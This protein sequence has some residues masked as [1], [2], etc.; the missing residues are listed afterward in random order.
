MQPKSLSATALHVSEL[1]LARYKAEHIDRAARV[2]TSAASLGTAV[3]GALEMFVKACYLDKTQQPS[4]QLL[5][6]LYRM[7]YMTTFGTSDCDTEQFWDGA[8]MLDRWAKRTVWDGITVLS[9]EVKENFPVPTSLGDI[10]FNYI[11]DRF[12]RIGEREVKVVDYKTNKWSINPADL[13]KKIQAR[14]YGVA[15]AIK[16]KSLGFEVDKVWVEF[17]LLRHDPVGIVFSREENAATWK[18]IK[19]AAQK[20]IDTPDDET[21]ESLNTECLFCV[22]KQTCKAIAS[23]IAAGGI[24]GLN[25]DMAVDRR[26]TLEYQ[27]K[28]I[29]KALEELDEFIMTEAREK[30]IEEYETDMNKLGFTARVTRAVDG[31]RVEQVVGHEVFQRYGGLSITMGQYDKMMKD[32]SIPEEQK[33]KLKQLVYKNVGEI[34]VKTEPRSPIDDE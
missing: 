13:K 29:S 24:F 34:R 15:A 31:E 17:D 9:C 33:R 22:R 14:C 12:D 6:D 11:W 19:E 2:G 20:I 10:P 30:D 4:G 16:A 7:S 32:P 5:G 8:E 26:A 27:K 1:C 18:F 25:L 3:H 21:P 23:N 28:A